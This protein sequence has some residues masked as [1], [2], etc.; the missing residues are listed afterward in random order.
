MVTARHIVKPNWPNVRNFC[1]YV[2][3]VLLIGSVIAAGQDIIPWQD[4][5]TYYGQIKIVEGTIVETKNTGKA[6]FLNFS[7]NW[8]TDF[9]AVIFASDFGKFP[10]NPEAYY[11]GKKVRVTGSIQ[12]YRG[13]PEIVLKIKTRL[14][15]LSGT[16]SLKV[17]P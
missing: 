3:T 16:R 2:A 9:T 7:P 17:P 10:P 14:C 8:R 6:C 12:E 15:S 5:A 1:L 4:A 13:K 11:R